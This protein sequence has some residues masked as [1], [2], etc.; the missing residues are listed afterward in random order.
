MK[1]LRI[2]KKSTCVFLRL[3]VAA[4][5]AGTQGRPVA[6]F[7]CFLPGNLVRSTSKASLTVPLTDEFLLLFCRNDGL[8]R[9]EL[10]RT[11]DLLDGE[12]R[13][14]ALEEAWTRLK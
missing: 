1:A 8:R 13:L 4:R 5:N 3:P 9:N 7:R 14:R 12:D 11:E 6:G 2:H 10:L